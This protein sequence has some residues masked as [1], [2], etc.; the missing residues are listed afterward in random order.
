MITEQQTNTDTAK[1]PILHALAGN[2]NETPPIWLMR[3]AGRY[4]SEYRQIRKD[5]G[6]FLNMCYSPSLASEVTL[7]PIRRFNFDAAI[8]F[9]DILVIPH[10]MGVGLDYI[11]GEGPV[12]EKITSDERIDKLKI[13]NILP[14]LEPVFEALRKTKKE[15]PEKT[16]LVGFAGA[17]WTVA[18]YMVEGGG[19]KQFAE[20]KTLAYNNP[21]L[22]E[23]LINILVDSTIT[24]LCAQVEAGAQ[25]LQIF[26]SWAAV[27]ADDGSFE[28]WCIEPIAK[29]VSGVKE[30]YPNIPI[31]GF[32]KGAGL[33]YEQFIHK[34]GIDGVGIDYS[35]P[36]KFAADKLQP[37]VCVQGNMD[38]LLL[39]SDKNM[40]VK[41]AKRIISIL[42][43][44]PFIFNL[45]HGIVPHTPI[46]H[47]QALIKTVRG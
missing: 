33:R 16:A 10:A 18:T 32:P 34:T 3:Q 21:V 12:L 31:I 24:Y 19:S 4:L 37:H 42:G 1:I 46:E 7:Q 47:V 22:F 39:A 14:H 28:K 9:S 44:G 20:V 41:E 40:A 36:L 38:P 17:P 26:D 13:D 29:I 43:D 30:K 2:S 27:L 23:R 8:I 6:G 11:N 25:V 5:A 45:G 15:L 35:V